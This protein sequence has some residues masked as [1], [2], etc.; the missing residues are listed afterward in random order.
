MELFD[1]PAVAEWLRSLKLD[2][3]ARAAEDNGVDGN[4]LVALAR[5]DGLTEL[6]VTSKLQIA[7]IKGGIA[8]L[9]QSAERAQANVGERPSKRARRSGPASPLTEP[10]AADAAPAEDTATVTNIPSMTAAER[11]IS[12]VDTW[13]PVVYVVPPPQNLECAICTSLVMTDPHTIRGGCSHSFCRT[14]LVTCLRRKPECPKCKHAATSA[15]G[16][17]ESLVLRNTDM[18][19]IAEEQKVHCP[20]GVKQLPGGG[21]NDWVLNPEGC[22]EQFAKGSAELAQH[23]AVCPHVP[24]GC[25]MSEHGCGWRGR[26]DGVTGHETE[27]VYAKLR[28]FMEATKQ[29]LASVAATKQQLAATKQQLAATK[30]Q[31]TATTARL[32]AAEVGLAACAAE[33]SVIGLVWHMTDAQ[34]T[35]RGLLNLYDLVDNTPDE[36]KEALI[37]VLCSAGAVEAVVAAMRGHPEDGDVQTHGVRDLSQLMFRPSAGEPALTLSRA[38]AAASAAAAAQRRYMSDKLVCKVALLAFYA[39]LRKFCQNSTGQVRSAIASH[40][41]AD[42]C[43]A[44]IDATREVFSNEDHHFATR[45]SPLLIDLLDSL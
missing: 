6:G 29:E 44:L 18:L 37:Q 14:C 25:S 30:Q 45:I 17:A 27:C 39:I 16:A 22:Q 11:K 32:A 35:L 38:K 42:G 31:L 34:A 40:M 21:S 4:V 10:A 23:L 15:E 43:R 26:R 7:K 24:T 13:P 3:V 12:E 5:E 33:G 8:K 20:G 9:A 36:S 2:A 28:P 19:G 41:N 1:A